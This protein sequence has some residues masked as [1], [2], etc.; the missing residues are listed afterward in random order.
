MNNLSEDTA[1]WAA[2][3]LL[4]YNNYKE[5]KWHTIADVEFDQSIIA[6][7]AFALQK[8]DTSTLKS[9]KHFVNTD[10]LIGKG[11]ADYN[12]LS[13]GD[14][15]KRRLTIQ[16]ELPDF[17]DTKSLYPSNDRQVTIEIPQNIIDFNASLEKEIPA[18]ELL[19]F[20]KNIYDPFCFEKKYIPNFDKIITHLENNA[21][22]KYKGPKDG[23][24]E[25][26]YK[27]LAMSGSSV[28]HEMFTLSEYLTLDLPNTY[29][30]S[31]S[32]WLDGSNIKVRDYLWVPIK[33]KKFKSCPSSISVFAE[34]P[35]DTENI[36]F[37][38][39]LEFDNKNATEKSLAQHHRFLE[40][41]IDDKLC[42]YVQPKNAHI[43]EIFRSNS[44]NE[45][46]LDQLNKNE[47]EKVQLVYV[48]EDM[49]SLLESK[50]NQE[51]SALLKEGFDLIKPYYDEIIKNSVSDEQ[52]E[53][54]DDDTLE[55]T[56]N[57][58]KNTILFGPPGT[59][60]TYSIV[61]HALNIVHSQDD[62]PIDFTDRNEVTAAYQ[63]FLDGEQILFCTFHQS[64]AYEDFVE[65]FR[66]D[67]NGVFNVEEGIFKRI[68]T[69]AQHNEEKNYVL[70]I[71]EI[72]R[73]NISKIFGELI[74]LIEEDKRIGETNEIQVTLPYSKE[75]FGVPKNLYIL[76]TMN[77]ADRSIA[78]MDNALRRR[79]DFEELMPNAQVL[80]QDIDGINVQALLTTINNRIEY[81]Y[82]R[83]HQ[84]GHAFFIG[85]NS[86][87]EIFSVMTKKVIP[88]LQE[89]F[90]N[91]WEKIAAVLGGKGSESNKNAYFI[92][93]KT[94]SM[95]NLFSSESYEALTRVA[96]NKEIYA[97]S[98]ISDN[99][100]KK[101]VI[102]NVYEK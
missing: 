101:S 65:G 68:C 10:Y 18:E 86:T 11:N 89:Y 74:T 63:R 80:P 71:D 81:L 13:P 7:L 60:K 82:D 76:G 16:Q 53:E 87:E 99:Y 64:F 66:S 5:G 38:I 28:V 30:F 15:R 73:G 58:S 35:T 51:I 69:L 8:E 31:N 47:I 1:V 54:K 9:Y 25:E 50:T 83:D 19:N 70:V 78:L 23:V 72:N 98:S 37:R 75:L 56:Q 90:F 95:E 21:N 22:A 46:L 55:N 67:E 84:I 27:N 14:K 88:L 41:E 2:T 100:T 39:S 36:R 61:D 59:G 17:D 33:K 57:T 52:V 42:Y 97:V 29:E 43:S 26:Q 94:V 96:E 3:A 91:D 45:E 85:K 102:K 48:L 92:E 93:S 40:K 34:K 32:K 6:K 44:S 49:H 4:T 20:V 62:E 12:F 24:Q 79:F 77:T